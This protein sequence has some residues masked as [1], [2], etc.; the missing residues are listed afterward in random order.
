MKNEYLTI[1]ETTIIYVAHKDG[2]VDE[3]LIDTADFEIANS[4]PGTWTTS[5][6]GPT[7]RSPIYCYANIADENNTTSKQ[8]RKPRRNLYLHRL[9]HGEPQGMDIDHINRNGLDN[10]RANLRVVTTADNVSRRV[11]YNEPAVNNTT[12]G[13]RNVSITQ[14]GKYQVMVCGVYYGSFDTI[15]EAAKVAADARMEIN[16]KKVA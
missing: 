16:R 14:S 5:K 11:L 12:T 7:S 2:R 10:R 13:V 9:L 3:V 1:G 15:T 8:K 6:T 4:I